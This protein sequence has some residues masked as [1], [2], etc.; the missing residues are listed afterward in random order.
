MFALT[1]LDQAISNANTLQKLLT[2][3]KIYTPM[4]DTM[5]KNKWKWG[6]GLGLANTGDVLFCSAT[7]QFVVGYLVRDR[8][9]ALKIGA[10]NL[11]HDTGTAFQLDQSSVTRASKKILSSHGNYLG[12]L[13]GAGGTAF[14]GHTCVFAS[15]GSS[16]YTRT[17]GFYQSD[18]NSPAFSIS[19]SYNKLI[20]E[21][22]HN[23]TAMNRT[24][25][26]TFLDDL[27]QGTV[28]QMGSS[29][30]PKWFLDV[31]TFSGKPIIDKSF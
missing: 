10:L 28:G 14:K 4:T 22:D 23:I 27:T 1:Y 5:V 31:V 8:K 16:S 6:K 26:A 25:F 3:Y 9:L 18:A 2:L 20:N 21:T 29:H 30:C 13:S 11:Y 7:V 12:I 19:K 15:F 24:K 17:W